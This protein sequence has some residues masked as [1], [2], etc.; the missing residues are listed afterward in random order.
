VAAEDPH[1]QVVLLCHWH[2]RRVYLLAQLL[3]SV[4]AVRLLL[5][6]LA[7]AI[8]LLRPLVKVYAPQQS[9]PR[10]D[11][12]YLLSEGL[13]IRLSRLR[14][15]A[16][17]VEELGQT[18]QFENPAPARGAGHAAHRG[19]GPRLR[20]EST[21]K[22]YFKLARSGGTLEGSKLVKTHKTGCDRRDDNN[23]QF[24]LPTSESDS[25]G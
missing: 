22:F 8:R 18:F 21:H 20:V 11:V 19:S 1:F 16:S 2:Y 14:V 12:V 23:S 13:V 9:A 3:D 7:L 17:A 24:K 10:D 15:E 6:L 5:L 25:S 4:R